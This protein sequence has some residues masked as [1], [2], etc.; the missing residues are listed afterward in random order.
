MK[1]LL[2]FCVLL[3]LAVA[4]TN[5]EVVQGLVSRILGAEY[6]D[7]FTF[8]TIPKDD[9]KDV[10]ELAKSGKD[11]SPIIIR[12]S[13]PVAM[14]TG[15]HN[16]LKYYCN[17]S[18]TWGEN[19]T[20][21]S[22]RLPEPLPEIKENWINTFNVQYRYY[23]NVC[24]VSYSSSFWDW[25][26]W[27][28]EI[29]WMA[30]HGVNM[31]LTFTGQEYIWLK[32]FTSF[33]IPEKDSLEYFSGPAFFAWLR[34]G[35][36]HSWGG[37]LTMNWLHQ[38]W[39][40]QKKIVQ[41]QKEYGMYQVYPAFAGFVPEA[42]KTV[43]PNATTT[44]SNNWCNFG[45]KYA[46]NTILDPQ[47]PLF[48]QI[49]SAFIKMMNEELGYTSHIYNTDT[50]NEMDP[51][52]TD[53]DYL[54]AVG[55][56]VYES[57]Q[58]AD[59][60]GIWLMQGW[61]FLSKFWTDERLES[62]LSGLDFDHTLILDLA[63]DQMPLFNRFIKNNKRWIWCMI[64]NYGGNRALYGDFDLLTT[65]TLSDLAAN[66]DTMVGMGMTPE[67]IEHNPMTYELMT[68]MMWRH[69]S[70]DI[71]QWIHDYIYRRYGGESQEAIDAWKL[72]RKVLLHQ[73]WGETGTL[74]TRPILN[75][76]VSISK[77]RDSGAIMNALKMMMNSRKDFESLTEP[78]KY[79]LVDIARQAMD[80]MFSELYRHYNHYANS[81]TYLDEYTKHTDT[82][83]PGN[84]LYRARKCGS[85]DTSI[86]C[87]ITELMEICNTEP[88][89]AGFNS[90]GFL[91]LTTDHLSSSP[92][93]DTYARKYI[94]GKYEVESLKVLTKE[95]LEFVRQYDKV[96][97]TN[98]N[99]LLGVWTRRAA[100]FAKDEEERL[101]LDFNAKNQVTLWGPDANIDDYATK[102]W[103][104]LV[105]SYHM[106]RWEM[107]TNTVNTF[108]EE[109]KTIDLTQYYK[110]VIEMGR[111]WDRDGKQY[112]NE[113]VGD[114]IL[115][116]Q[117]VIKKY[118]VDSNKKFDIK[119]NMSLNNKNRFDS[120][121]KDIS[122]L[123]YNCDVD[124]LCVAFTND[125]F[126]YT[127][128]S[129]PV[130]QQGTILY[131]KK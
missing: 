70:V 79:D 104:G 2:L 124:P 43:Y 113:P 116:V 58:L 51:K 123:A 93:A 21:N 117:K 130:E 72:I 95:I 84:D 100:S 59:P 17:S 16:Y 40:I 92:G 118:L 81:R 112:P 87:N 108:A 28:K 13:D 122:M 62:Y 39:E 128:S 23:M 69:E 22:I 86:L 14:A 50:F 76:G 96:L 54:H 83:A 19:G 126:Y 103:N 49:G 114:S 109:G 5:S 61:Q 15:L 68:E 115:E 44:T 9:G 1:R 20:G 97:G 66:K 10:F 85:L 34:M 30:L 106:K 91:K 80:Y 32:V 8:E 131:M 71:D 38:E 90:N 77:E 121:T 75:R 110:D 78:W 52:S 101:W 74:V 36:I 11:N 98:P 73:V 89:C 125:G 56:V 33:G 129:N 26:R 65:K 63:S 107:F 105:G 45:Q 99:F 102:P 120:F 64:H 24:T 127:N 60:E 67:A 48:K 25:N 53:L 7:K 37:P 111:Q 94:Q 35:N 46:E 12:G 4:Q 29:D 88:L 18:I 47:D 42:I 31:P 3:C 41:R 6:I 119:E 82:D 27:E 55:K 57:I